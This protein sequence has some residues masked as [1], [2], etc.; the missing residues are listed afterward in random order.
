MPSVKLV[1]TALSCLLVSSTHAFGAPIQ[2]DFN[3]AGFGPTDEAHQTFTKMLAGRP[4]LTFDAL[5]SGLLAQG[6]LHWDAADG[7]GFGDGFGVRDF[8][9]L[10]TADAFPPV[11]DTYSQD[12][13]EA[14]ERLRLTFSA[15]VQLVSFN[16][17]DMFWENESA[18][19]GLPV[20]GLADPN[21]YLEFGEYSINGGA[22]WTPFSADPSELRGNLSN[23]TVIVNVNQLTTSLI[24][25]APGATD[26]GGFPYRQLHDY[27]LAGVKIEQAV[28]EPA[29]LLLLGGGLVIFAAIQRRRI[30][31]RS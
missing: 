31:R 4:T 8:G 6:H 26:V 18:L 28:P 3:V 24:L 27:S 19:T 15:P 30:A 11:G 20:C 21:C 1:A 14:N 12:E 23:G 17:T 29:T 9:N 13:I 10:F 2:I 22:T 16:V 7:N 25:R 5:D